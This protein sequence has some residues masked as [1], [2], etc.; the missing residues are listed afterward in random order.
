MQQELQ[1]RKAQRQG[2]P[3][4]SGWEWDNAG[5]IFRSCY[6]ASEAHEGQSADEQLIQK[7][8]GLEGM[9]TPEVPLTVLVAINDGR[10]VDF[11]DRYKERFPLLAKQ[12][13][14]SRNTM[15]LK[16]SSVW[17][18]DLK[19]RSFVNFPNVEDDS[20]FVQVLQRLV[21]PERWT[22]CNDCVAK[23]ICPLR[24]NA[25]S[26]R[27]KRVQQR[28][29][30]LLL[31]AHLRRQ[32][33][34]TMR[35]LRSVLAYLIT[36]NASCEHIRF[37]R[38]NEEVGASL[39]NLTYWRSC[40]APLEMHD[41]LLNDMASLDPG[42]FPQPHLDRYLHF[43]QSFS[44][45][46]TRRAIFADDVDLS[47]QRFKDEVEWIAAVKRRLYFEAKPAKALEAAVRTLPRVRARSLLPYR[48]AWDFVDL[49]DNNFNDEG[50]CLLRE[51][52]ALGILH[53]DGIIEDVPDGTLS[54][55][56]CSSEDQQLIV[57]KQFPLE[58]FKLYPEQISERDII[59]RL[60]EI[61][62]SRT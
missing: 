47:V 4:A 54:V 37:A 46:E 59:E 5:H 30:Y 13:E 33:H 50:I 22:I 29:E 38:D 43:H 49:L 48:Y 11:F 41:E 12:V 18:V 42:R 3:D 6:D 39:V 60:P 51:E 23:T 10:L 28:L 36:G 7:L 26:L 45:A 21:A 35:D 57:L 27:K 56:V 16:S 25:T 19:R 34:M 17:V 14:Q 24:N 55:Q 52:I 32:R 15:A 62:D 20:I 9:Q 8:Q 31:L 58:D 61:I 40:F 2:E 53:S 44:D 1:A